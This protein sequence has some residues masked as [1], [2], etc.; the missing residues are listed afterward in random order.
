M[1]TV[2]IQRML[3]ALEQFNKPNAARVEMGYFEVQGAKYGI[4]AKKCYYN[5]EYGN[6]LSTI[7]LMIQYPSS[8]GL[9]WITIG[10]FSTLH[11]L[12]FMGYTP[13][14]RIDKN[15]ITYKA[16]PEQSRVECEISV[17]PMK[18]VARRHTFD[19]FG[20]ALEDIANDFEGQQF[21]YNLICEDGMVLDENYNIECFNFVLSEFELMYKGEST[22]TCIDMVPSYINSAAGKFYLPYDQIAG[23]IERYVQSED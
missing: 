8:S 11:P 12:S 16:A 2:A 6:E 14:I 13:K 1:N 21:Q 9:V 3:R 5:P 17:A 19:V 23:V 10:E 18:G 15:W 4:R 22:I 7:E 20:E